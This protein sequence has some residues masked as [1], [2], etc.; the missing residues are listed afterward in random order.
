MIRSTR[1]RRTLRAASTLLLVVGALVVLDVVVTYFWQEPVTALVAK[2]R[3]DSLGN[4]LDRLPPAGATPAERHQ[5]AVLDN[6]PER[7]GFLARG[8]A[9]QL[10]TGDPAARIRIPKIGASFV[11]VYGSDANSLTKGPGFY[12]SQPLPGEHGTVAIAGHRTTYLAPFRHVD[13]LR[14]GDQIQITP[15]YGRFTYSVTG[16]RRVAPDSRWVLDRKPDDQLVLTA[17]D[18]PFSAARRIV[19]F[20]K[21]RT[22]RLRE[23][24][25]NA[26]SNA[27]SDPAADAT[28]G[29]APNAVSRPTPAARAADASAPQRPGG[30]L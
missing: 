7:L 11:V 15:P 1:V 14:R 3:Q 9:K 28:T 27:A 5:L 23:A 2:F 17:C 4:Q 19:V 30:R 22:A 13:Q 26:T 18:P 16:I 20:A 21:L 10:H 6:T 8:F 25:P 12:P 29:A 24:T